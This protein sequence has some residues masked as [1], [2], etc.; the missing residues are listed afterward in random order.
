MKPGQEKWIPATS[1]QYITVDTPA[2]VWKVHMDMIP[3]VAVAGCDHFINA[4]GRMNVKLLSLVDM[5]NDADEKIDQGALQR[6]L[7]E[8]SW[9]PSAAL[10]PYIKWEAIDSFSAKATMTYKNTSGSVIFHFNDKGDMVYCTADRYMGGGDKA[11]LEKW[12]GRSMEIGVMDGIR[13]PVK[14]EVTWKLK[15]GDFT[16]YKLGVTELEYNKPQLYAPL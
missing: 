5:V 15:A 6:Y 11:T 14:S 7:S 1:E 4:K 8:I 3:F 9:A 10:L 16:W 2:F 12:E 13:M